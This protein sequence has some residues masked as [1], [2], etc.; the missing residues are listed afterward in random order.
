MSKL[1]LQQVSTFSVPAIH[2]Y[3]NTKGYSI[4]QYNHMPILHENPPMQA[5]SYSKYQAKTTSHPNVTAFPSTH[6]P[7]YICI[8]ECAC[9]RAHT[10]THM[11]ITTCIPALS[12]W[13]HYLFLWCHCLHIVLKLNAGPHYS[14]VFL[15]VNE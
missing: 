11:L 4:N 9:A 7:T 10:H 13:V 3:M 1:E 8:N 12:E 5:N 6:T 14:H 15:L 2:T